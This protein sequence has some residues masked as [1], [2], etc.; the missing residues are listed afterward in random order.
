MILCS[1][2]E[3]QK[4]KSEDGRIRNLIFLYPSSS[5]KKE[6]VPIVTSLVPSD[7]FVSCERTIAFH[8]MVQIE[9]QIF[10]SGKRF[11]GWNCS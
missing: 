7:C 9:V 5:N 2:V 1:L 3:G 11:P 6:M 8:G 4:G 10:V